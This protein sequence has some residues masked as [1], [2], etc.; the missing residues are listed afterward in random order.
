MRYELRSV[1]AGTFHTN[2]HP[3]NTTTTTAQL[4]VVTRVG[5]KIDAFELWC[6]RRLLRVPWTARRTNSPS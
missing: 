3:R 4:S 6:W 1:C 2:L 5:Q